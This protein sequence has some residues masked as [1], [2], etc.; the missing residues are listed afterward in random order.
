M[1]NFIKSVLLLTIAVI[2]INTQNALSQEI[3][4]GELMFVNN[5]GTSG[6]NITIDVYPVGAIFNGA[7]EYAFKAVNAL[8]DNPYIF[9]IHSKVLSKTLM[10]RDCQAEYTF[11][12]Y[13]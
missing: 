9:G 12:N 6:Y 7:D 11:I 4:D 3:R 1:K 5:T 8:P 10:L 2:V 13:R